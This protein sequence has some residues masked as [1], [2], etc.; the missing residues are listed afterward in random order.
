METVL[1]TPELGLGLPL[2]P[3]EKQNNLMDIIY[4]INRE[5]STS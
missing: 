2:P 3:F 1:S 4:F 5:Y